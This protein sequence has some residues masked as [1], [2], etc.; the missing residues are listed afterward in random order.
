[1]SRGLG[2]VSGERHRILLEGCLSVREIDE[3][4]CWFEGE[5]TSYPDKLLIIEPCGNPQASHGPK[6]AQG[7]DGIVWKGVHA[8]RSIGLVGRVVEFKCG[9]SD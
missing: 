9:L 6:I 1:M 3:I 5:K 2:G 4:V 7:L 8:P